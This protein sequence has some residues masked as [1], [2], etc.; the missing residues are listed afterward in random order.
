MGARIL[1]VDDDREDEEFIREILGQLR[2]SEV[3]FFSNG[4][5][6]LA[7]L[8]SLIDKELPSLVVS[9]MNLPLL[10]GLELAK[11][12]KSNIRYRGIGMVIYSGSLNPATRVQFEKIGV[13]EIVEKQGHLMELRYTLTRFIKLATEAQLPAK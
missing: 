10:N 2:F 3:E 1:F 13:T 9:D 5:T 7:H 8:K 11:A 6:V 12:I 4:Q